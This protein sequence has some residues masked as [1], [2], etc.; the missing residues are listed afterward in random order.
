LAV[1]GIRES[2][3]GHA[4]AG[5]GGERVGQERVEGGARPHEAPLA[6]RDQGRGELEGGQRAGAAPEHAAEIWSRQPILPGHDG[7]TGVASLKE[8]LASRGVSP[9]GGH[10]HGG[11]GEREADRAGPARHLVR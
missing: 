11:E 10:H 9:R 8:T 3:H 1:G 7:V 6:G 5:Q 2:R 4:R